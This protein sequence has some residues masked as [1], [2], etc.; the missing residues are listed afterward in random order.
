MI[1]VMI[2]QGGI[3]KALSTMPDLQQGLEM[4]VMMI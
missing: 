3:G 1:F 2:Q 4:M